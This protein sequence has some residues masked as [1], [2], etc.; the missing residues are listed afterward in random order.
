M[1]HQH[2]RRCPIG[3]G[4]SHARHPGPRPEPAAGTRTGKRPVRGGR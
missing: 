1:R 4:L 2:R 3:A